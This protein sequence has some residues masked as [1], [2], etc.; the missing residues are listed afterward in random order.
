MNNCPAIG[1]LYCFKPVHKEDIVW[2]SNTAK[3]SEIIILKKD[4]DDIFLL[5]RVDNNSFNKNWST[6]YFLLNSQTYKLS[7]IS[8]GTFNLYFKEINNET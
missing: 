7:N 8:V 6:F 1:T 5:T 2:L 3:K 4:C